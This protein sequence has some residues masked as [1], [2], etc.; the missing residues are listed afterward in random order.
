MQAVGEKHDTNSSEP[1]GP[2]RSD[3]RLPFHRTNGSLKTLALAFGLTPGGASRPRVR[4]SG[5]Q[6]HPA[7][8]LPKARQN[9]DEEHDTAVSEAEPEESGIGSIDHVVPSHR[10]AINWLVP[11]LATPTATQVAGS[12]H[13]IA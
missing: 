4:W 10:S 5:A 13:E 1:G 8:H 3:Q 11:F 12:E 9:D 2:R 7:F 6:P